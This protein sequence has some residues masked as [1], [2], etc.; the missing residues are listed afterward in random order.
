[1]FLLWRREA[2]CPSLIISLTDATVGEMLDLYAALNEE[3]LVPKGQLLPR[4]VA[5]RKAAGLDD[6]TL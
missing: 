5:R 2:V 3:A 4:M 6:V 1:M